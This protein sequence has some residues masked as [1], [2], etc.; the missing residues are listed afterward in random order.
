M[1]YPILFVP[2]P[3][4]SKRLCVDYQ[5]L[6]AITIKNSYALPLILELQDRLQGAKWFTKFDIPVAYHQIRIK[7]GEEWKTAFRTCLGHYEYQVM[8]FG[9]TN[10]PATFQSYINNV[11]QEY[12][13]VFVTVYIDDILIYSENEEEH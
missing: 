4:S 10:A 7:A 11:L 1:G 12:L 5:K 13:D 2:K 3:D 8:P 6:N 9:L